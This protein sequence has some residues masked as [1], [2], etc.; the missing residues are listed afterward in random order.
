MGFLGYRWRNRPREVS[1]Q[2]VELRAK[3]RSP[4]LCFLTGKSISWK[5]GQMECGEPRNPGSPGAWSGAFGSKAE[6]FML[7]S[8]PGL[9]F[10]NSVISLRPFPP[11]VK[12]EVL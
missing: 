6:Y 11:G 7:P 8:P 4:V 9:T 10:C 2:V 3:P 12:L 5:W 1:E